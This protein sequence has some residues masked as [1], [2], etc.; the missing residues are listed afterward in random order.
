MKFF[1]KKRRF[2]KQ[3]YYFKIVSDNGRILCS[4]EGYYNSKDILSTID[5]MKKNI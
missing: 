2:R 1:V 3:K 5:S 4:S